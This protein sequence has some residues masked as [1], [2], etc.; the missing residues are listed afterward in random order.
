MYYGNVELLF[1]NKIKFVYYYSN[2]V[3]ESRKKYYGNFKLL[4]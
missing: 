3:D 2:M 4:R 1:N